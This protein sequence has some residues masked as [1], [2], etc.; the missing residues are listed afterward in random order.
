L[1]TGLIALGAS[2]VFVLDVPLIRLILVSQVANGVLL[3]FILFYI[4][5]RQ[6]EG[7]DGRLHELPVRERG[8]G[9]NQRGHGRAH[10]RIGGMTLRGA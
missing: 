4:E 3:P 5:T 8:R 9:M 6:S 1:Y 2:I 7:I 10:R